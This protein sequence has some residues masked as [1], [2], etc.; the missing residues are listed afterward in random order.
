SSVFYFLL[1]ERLLTQPPTVGDP[2][3]PSGSPEERSTELP[4]REKLRILLAYEL[5]KHIVTRETSEFCALD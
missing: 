3:P 4:K 2:T 1:G 5:R